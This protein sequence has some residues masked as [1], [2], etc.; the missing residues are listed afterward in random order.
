MLCVL[1]GQKTAGNWG[2]DHEG[3]GRHAIVAALYTHI[4][5][6]DIS[7]RHAMGDRKVYNHRHMQVTE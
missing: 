4:L 1:T 7:G 2:M 6:P 5:L 3:M